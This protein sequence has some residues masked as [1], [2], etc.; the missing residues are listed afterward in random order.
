MTMTAGNFFPFSG[1]ARKA[2]ISPVS[3]GYL[4]NSETMTVSFFASVACLYLIS[5]Y[6]RE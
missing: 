5:L 6:D 4:I 3:A 1:L 2:L